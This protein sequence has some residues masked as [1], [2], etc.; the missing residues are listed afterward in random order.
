MREQSAGQAEAQTHQ[1][2]QT[3][4]CSIRGG[5]PADQ[6]NSAKRQLDPVR[7]G[8]K[9]IPVR[10]RDHRE[11]HADEATQRGRPLGNKPEQTQTKNQKPT[12]SGRRV[13]TGLSPSALFENLVST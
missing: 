7:P 13:L 2:T 5:L 3:R 4:G 9:R 8:L 12:I 10:Q 6:R 11:Q 1:R